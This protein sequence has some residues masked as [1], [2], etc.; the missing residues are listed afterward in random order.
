MNR[1]EFVGSG[2][3]L[4]AAACMDPLAGQSETAVADKTGRPGRVVTVGAKPKPIDLDLDKTAVL[5]VDMQNDFCA[6]GGILDR[7]GID[8]AIIQRIIPQIS[9]TLS[10]ARKLGLKIV[11]LKMGYKPDLSDI[12]PKGSINWINNQDVGAPVTA[13]NGAQS[14]ILI[15]DTWNTEITPELKP[16]PS[17]TVVYK[18][19]FSGFY[20][21]GLEAILEGGGIRSLVV[22]GCTTSVCVESTIRDAMFRDFSVV[23]LSDCTAE[24]E[25]CDLPR[26]NHEAS[27]YLIEK[28]FGW[29]S[30]SEQLLQAFK[31]L[32]AQ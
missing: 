26:S 23:L 2:I 9:A 12:G 21:T 19:R 31:Q 18:T 15:R 13:P 5:V 17:D 10:G 28:D 14:R 16:E 30:T 7:Q 22:I 20:K 6:K 8:L 11:Y 3:A 27:L 25:G 4:T 32:P 1:R 24:P 29:V